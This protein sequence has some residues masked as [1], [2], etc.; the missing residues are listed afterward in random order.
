MT[1]IFIRKRHSLSACAGAKDYSFLS[2]SFLFQFSVSQNRLLFPNSNP[3]ELGPHLSPP[4]GT[5]VRDRDK[6]PLSYQDEEQS[7]PGLATRSPRQSQL[8]PSRRRPPQLPGS[9]SP[10]ARPPVM[11]RGHQALWPLLQTGNQPSV[12]EGHPWDAPSKAGQDATPPSHRRRLSLFCN[13]SWLQYRLLDGDSW[14]LSGTI[15]YNTILQ[16]DL[17]CKPRGRWSD[18]SCTMFLPPLG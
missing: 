9:P 6:C 18:T 11:T 4:L 13:A 5:S 2:S 15:N 16:L 17:F 10:Q 3:S 8:G 1:Q 7:R 14:P 12:H